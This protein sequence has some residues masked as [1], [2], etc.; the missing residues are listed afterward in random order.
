MAP[1][2]AKTTNTKPQNR[3]INYQF[4]RRRTCNPCGYK[5]KI[6]FRYYRLLIYDIK[7]TTKID[8]MITVIAD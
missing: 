1:S 6:S 7:R 3:Q 8:G 2:G 4:S 5:M